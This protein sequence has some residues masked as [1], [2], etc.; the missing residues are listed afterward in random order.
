MPSEGSLPTL[1][2]VRS[3][4]PS[5]ADRMGMQATFMGT[6][7]P[8]TPWY[9]WPPCLFHRLKATVILIQSTL[10]PSSRFLPMSILRISIL[11]TESHTLSSRRHSS[12]IH[13][14]P[15]H[16]SISHTARDANRNHPGAFTLLRQLDEVDDPSM[17]RTMSSCLLRPRARASWTQNPS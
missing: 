4:E 17:T 14:K 12:L 6:L 5:R 10:T 8:H 1:G 7:C 16:T 11:E 13:N 15:S 2:W 3:L 9:P